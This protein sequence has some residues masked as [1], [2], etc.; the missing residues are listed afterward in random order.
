MNCKRIQ[1]LIPDYLAGQIPSDELHLFESHLSQ[2]ETC[3]LELEYMEKTWVELADFPDEEPSPDLRGRFYP[4]LEAEKRRLGES[5]NTSWWRRLELWLEA[6]WPRR[7]AVQLMMTAAVLMVGMAAG[8][9]FNAGEGSKEELA[10]M[11]S[12]IQ[13]MNQM[14]S[15]SLLSQDSSSERLRGVNWSTRVDVPSTRL[16]TNLT[17]ILNS[18]PNEN[19]RLA[20]VDA[21]TF[22]PHESG[23]LDALSLALSQESSPMV[24]VALIDFLIALQEKKAL[25]ALK[26]FITKPDVSPSVKKHAESKIHALL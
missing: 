6:W 3:R 13:Q 25:E 19:V 21:L 8:S 17:R 2:C 22:F 10:H 4:M 26:I 20:A 14:V 7:P 24:Q 5:A 11:R 15:L 23:V 1:E 9:R 12:E 16:L 18:D